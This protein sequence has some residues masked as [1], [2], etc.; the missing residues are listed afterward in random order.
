MRITRENIINF[1]VDDVLNS[2]LW[3]ESNHKKSVFDA[4]TFEIARWIYENTA[5][6]R[7]ITVFTRVIEGRLQVYLIDLGMR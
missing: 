5:S 4:R 1:S 6:Q 7:H 3:L 2:L